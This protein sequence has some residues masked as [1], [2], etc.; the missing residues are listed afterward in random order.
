MNN[1]K[2]ILAEVKVNADLEDVWDAWTTEKGIKTFF[3]PACKVDLRPDGMYE[4]YFNPGSPPGERGGEGLRVMSILPM[5]MF[6]FTWNAPPILPEVRGQRTHVVVRFVPEEGGTRVTLYHDGW[7]SGGEWDKAFEY[8]QKAWK[9][10]VLPR[11]KYRFEHGP[12]DWNDP[13]SI[14]TLSIGS[15]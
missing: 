6:S 11:L 9:E 5:K 8:F 10:V 4:V 14:E 2:A 15:A 7:G 12:I 3:A 1:E 13:P